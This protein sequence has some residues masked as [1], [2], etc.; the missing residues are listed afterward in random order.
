MA[1]TRALSFPKQSA[2]ILLIRTEYPSSFPWP[3]TPMTWVP[4]NFNVYE[5]T[6]RSLGPPLMYKIPGLLGPPTL[7]AKLLLATT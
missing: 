7:S 1:V 6:P 2:G 3:I 4:H 5:Q